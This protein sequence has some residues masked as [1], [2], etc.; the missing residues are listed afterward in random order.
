MFYFYKSSALKVSNE[1]TLKLLQEQ[2]F[3]LHKIDGDFCQFRFVP[4]SMDEKT[5]SAAVV[6]AFHDLGLKERLSINQE[7][8]SRY[9]PY[10]CPQLSIFSW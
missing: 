5:T 9:N 8:L 6:A 7:T 4:R 2:S 3:D 10:K 1:E